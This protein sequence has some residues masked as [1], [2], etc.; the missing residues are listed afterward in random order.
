VD[1]VKRLLLREAGVQP[2]VILFE[3]L[4][5][6]DD[7]SQTLLDSIVESAAA[8]R[9]LLLVNYRPEYT[10]GWVNKAYYRQIRI[11]PLAT[12]TAEELLHSLVGDEADLDALKRRLIERT[13]GNPFF[14][15]ETIRPCATQAS[16]S[17]SSATSA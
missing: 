6:L 17:A 9:L 15:E 16:S 10:H 5:W 8:A 11:G 4:H 1:G 13:E 2:L 12:A 3:D 14:L 7:E